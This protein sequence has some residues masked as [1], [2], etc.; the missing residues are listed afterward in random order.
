MIKQTFIHLLF[1]FL[2][3][4]LIVSCDFDNYDDPSVGIEGQITDIITGDLF[5]SEQPD[6]Y[7]IRL[8][9]QGYTDPVPIDFWGRAD[10]TFEN[11]KLFPARY[12]VVPVEGAFFPADTVE[13][14]VQRGGTEVGFTVTPFLAIS[15]SAELIPDN[16]VVLTYSISRDRVGDKIVSVQ[17]LASERPVVNTTV[18][19]HRITRN[20]T[21]ID[22]EQILQTQFSDTLQNLQSGQTYY[23]RVAARTDNFLG[24]Y[25]YSQSFEI[26]IP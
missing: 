26:D 3:F 6:G 12:K 24:R 25:N 19:D 20:L 9:E 11:S 14:D 2:S 13:V 1:M 22:D 10:G 7:R 8:I 4:F 23:F 15:A 17:S 16:R 21:D 5:Q 18:F